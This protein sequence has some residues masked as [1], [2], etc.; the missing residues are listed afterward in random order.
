MI[1]LIVTGKGGNGFHL[2]VVEAGQDNV[3]PTTLRDVRD[4][5]DNECGDDFIPSN[6]YIF[7]YY[8]GDR[9]TKLAKQFE[10]HINACDFVSKN[11][12]IEPCSKSILSA[13]K[14][15]DATK[16]PNK[17]KKKSKKSTSQDSTKSP[18]KS[19][20]V[21]QE[22]AKKKL[23][24]ARA[25]AYRKYANRY[26]LHRKNSSAGVGRMGGGLVPTYVKPK[27]WS[28][29]IW[30]SKNGGLIPEFPLPKHL[31]D[32]E[33]DGN[34]MD[35]FHVLAWSTCW[36]VNGPKFACQPTAAVDGL[37]QYVKQNPDISFPVFMKRSM[38]SRDRSNEGLLLGWEY[39]GNYRSI[40]DP[41]VVVWE[42]ASR[43]SKASKQAIAKGHYDSSQSV[44]GTS[45]GRTKLD[46]WRDK[47]IEETNNDNSPAGPAY[48]I[49]RRMP[50]PEEADEKPASLAARARALN[51]TPNMEDDKLAELLVEID[52]FHRQ[53]CIEFDY[54]D[55]RVYDYCC[56]GKNGRTSRN[57]KGKKAASPN[58]AA[59]AKAWYDFANQHMLLD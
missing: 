21:K 58:E 29:H 7:T 36:Q 53:H 18:S 16:S 14:K 24:A 9:K 51:F 46:Q 19:P 54:Y 12:S 13:G 20:Q 15:R 32:T 30:T 6:E 10:M 37:P 2:C 3:A 42:S 8:I 38:T 5:I 22:E 41:D 48:L 25:S 4:C 31:N 57:S 39:V 44:S 34:N 28:S 1:P 47:L 56:N 40:S 55:E 59:T 17:E 26:L 23:K 52:E 33:V 49:E 50:T 27:K 45:Y 35:D 43:Y 11:L